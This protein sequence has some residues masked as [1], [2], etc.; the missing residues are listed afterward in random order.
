MDFRITDFGT[1]W[2]I[3][4]VS[5]DAIAFA[6]ENFPVEGWQGLAANFNT[7]HRA[8]RALVHQLIDEGWQV[9]VN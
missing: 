5:A 1:V 2:N 8:A 3:Q 6:E 4:A 7:D 9:L